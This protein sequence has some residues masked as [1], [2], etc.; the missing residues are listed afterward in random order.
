[1]GFL[2]G[3]SSAVY[4]GA[5]N[6]SPYFNEWTGTRSVEPAET[7]TYG[8]NGAAKTYIVGL[9]DATIT[10]KGK[11]DNGASAVD[12]HFNGVIAQHV[13]TSTPLVSATYEFG[14]DGTVSGRIRYTGEC[15][16]TNYEVGSPVGDVVTFSAQM[17]C[18]GPITRNT[19]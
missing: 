15:I 4:Y 18:T 11:F 12:A 14:P 19:F 7:T 2:H 16:V 3:K 8:V 13:N 1:M 5:Y 9:Q 6:L 17:Q 10:V